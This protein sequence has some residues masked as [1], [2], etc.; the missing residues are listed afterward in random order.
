MLLEH[1]LWFAIWDKVMM[2]KRLLTWCPNRREEG[3]RSP[4]LGSRLPQGL[5]CSL[6]VVRILVAIDPQTPMI[7]NEQTYPVSLEEA[8]NL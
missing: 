4:D 3:A 7:V 2:M 1:V 6:L 5:L 8:L